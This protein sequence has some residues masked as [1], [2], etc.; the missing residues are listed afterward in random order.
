LK[1]AAGYI[2]FDGL[3][4]LEASLRSIRKSVDTVIVAYQLQSWTGKPAQSD[5]IQILDTLK[6]KRLIDHLVEFKEFR[7]MPFDT[8]DQVK[9]VK[10]FELMKRQRC[11]DLAKQLGATHYLSMDSDECYRAQEFEWAKQQIIKD[12]LDVTCVH[13]INYVTPTLHRGY[14]RWKVPFIYRI[15]SACRHNALQYHLAGV[16]P[17]RG[18]FDEAYS[19]VKIFE[20]SQISMHHMEMVRR[21]ILAKYES[22]SRF[23]PNRNELP[24]LAKDINLARFKGELIFTRAHFGD[25]DNPREVYKLVECQNE[26]GILF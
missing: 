1:L 24:Q 13:Y 15:T 11:L 12:S 21:N 18:L 3:E 9:I 4:V 23:F 7:P 2:V 5:L 22:S 19:K 6:K 26:F 20:S 16:D 8:P 10:G 17:T 14:A 25:S